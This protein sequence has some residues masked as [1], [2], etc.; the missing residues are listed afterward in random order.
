[1]EDAGRTSRR[2]RGAVAGRGGREEAA[3][4]RGGCGGCG[5]CQQH[6]PPPSGFLLSTLTLP[7]L[8]PALGWPPPACELGLSISRFLMSAAMD[9]NA[10]T[11]LMFDFALVSKNCTQTAAQPAH[12]AL[13]SQTQRAAGRPRTVQPALQLQYRA[14]G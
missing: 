14:Q 13:S 11:T 9:V 8:G 5:G 7:L 4:R 1:M 3:G 10:S 6:P 2:R 12:A